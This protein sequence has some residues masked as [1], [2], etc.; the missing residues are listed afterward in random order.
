GGRE[1]NRLTITCRGDRA[2]YQVTTGGSIAKVLRDS[3]LVDPVSAEVGHQWRGCGGMATVSVMD[4]NGKQAVN[5]VTQ[6][7]NGYNPTDVGFRF[8]A[9]TPVP[10]K[11]FLLSIAEVL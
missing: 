4:Y 2:I 9:A 6:K 3:R 11:P 8:G 1:A 7:F 10:G 5:Y